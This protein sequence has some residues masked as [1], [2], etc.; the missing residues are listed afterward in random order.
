MDK[1]RVLQTLREH[2]PEL[3]A[4]GIVH[5]RLFG[6]LARGEGTPSSDVDLIADLDRS[7]RLTLLNMVRLENRLSD[8][9]NAKVDLSLAESLKEVVRARALREAISAF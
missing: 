2:E 1:S 4:E 5:L 8:L 3:K 7:K 6:S 9:L